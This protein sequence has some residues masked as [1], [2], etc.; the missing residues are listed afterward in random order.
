ML[1]KKQLKLGNVTPGGTVN[2]EKIVH[3]RVPGT[4]P[5]LAF[6]GTAVFC[7]HPAP[8]TSQSSEGELFV[9]GPQKTR[10]EAVP[11]RDGHALVESGP[12]VREQRSVRGRMLLSRLLRHGT[13]PQTLTAP[14]L[15]NEHG[16]AW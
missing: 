2:P 16:G 3:A 15:R 8:N 1:L 11:R 6:S 14:R 4:T 10:A 5:G 13:G 7:P 12:A 9:T